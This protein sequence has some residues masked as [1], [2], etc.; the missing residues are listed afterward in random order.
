MEQEYD[1][2]KAGMPDDI[3][4]LEAAADLLD[5]LVRGSNDE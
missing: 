1:K 5:K 3:E 4:E 2:D